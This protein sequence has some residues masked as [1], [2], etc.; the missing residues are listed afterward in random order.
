MA[1]GWKRRRET[2]V[3][4]VEVEPGWGKGSDNF[5]SLMPYLYVHDRV[6]HVMT[7][8]FNQQRFIFSG[9]DANHKKKRAHQC[10]VMIRICKTC[11]S[12]NFIAKIL[13]LVCACASEG[14]FIYLT[15]IIKRVNN[16]Y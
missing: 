2:E 5:P 7:R 10:R 8:I 1:E 13:L 12:Q 4:V 9:A 3:A 16:Q 11:M 14:L 6:G 15:R